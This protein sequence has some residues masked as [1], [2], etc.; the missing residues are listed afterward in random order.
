[1]TKYLTDFLHLIPRADFV[2]QF[3]K[4][5]IVFFFSK[6]Y[7]LFPFVILKCHMVADTNSQYVAIVL[8]DHSWK[9]RNY[10]NGDLTFH[11]ILMDWFLSTFLIKKNCIKC[12][13]QSCLHINHLRREKFPGHDKARHQLFNIQSNDV[14]ILTEGLW[15]N[16]DVKEDKDLNCRKCVDI[17]LLWSATDK[18]SWP[19]FDM[20]LIPW[21]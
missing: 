15:N 1:M 17:L 8:S 10:P 6:V 14:L 18:Q 16:S 12:Y 19:V 21:E 3:F 2:K 4:W 5:L 7:V 13:C 9:Q 20:L 11:S